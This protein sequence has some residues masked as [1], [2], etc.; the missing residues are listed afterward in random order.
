MPAKT[1]TFYELGPLRLDPRARVLTHEGVPVGLGARAVSVLAVLVD[2]APEYVAKSAILEAAWPG[3]V[4]E[5]ANLAVQISAIRA[6]LAR[7]PG[8][9]GWIETLPRRGYRF[10]GPVKE[11]SGQHTPTVSRD[12]KRTNLPDLLTSFIGRARELSEIKE[13]L[14]KTRLLTLTGTGGIGKT[15]LAQH[16]ATQIL[17]GYPDGVWFV[18]LAPLRDPALVT[19]AVAQV[20]QVTDSRAQT[21]D[22]ALCSHVGAKQMLLILDNCEHV[23]S[24][25]TRL[26]DM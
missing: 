1:A 4:V 15:R 19:K 10:N 18:D 7:V 9:D 6:A 17:D 22:D 24:A 3:L 25:C 8:G 11:S 13:L 20:L 2:S 26:S 16:C 14:P 23:L 5:E 12:P 21:L